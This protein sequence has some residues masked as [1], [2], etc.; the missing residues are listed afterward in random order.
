MCFSSFCFDLILS[1]TLIANVFSTWFEVFLYR[2]DITKDGRGK[3]NKQHPRSNS[4]SGCRSGTD[5]L[6]R[7]DLNKFGVPDALLVD[8]FLTFLPALTRQLQFVNANIKATHSAALAA[9]LRSDGCCR[10]HQHQ[11][12]GWPGRGSLRL[13]S[14]LP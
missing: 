3:I 4:S 12:S 1:F 5:N 14:Q 7:L 6:Q 11:H 8:P 9:L 10:T 13:L 2:F